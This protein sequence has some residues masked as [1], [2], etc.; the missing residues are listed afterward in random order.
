MLTSEME[1]A[2]KIKRKTGHKIY[3]N[4]WAAY[5]MLFNWGSGEGRGGET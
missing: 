2:S 3:S 1:W 4:F 5:T